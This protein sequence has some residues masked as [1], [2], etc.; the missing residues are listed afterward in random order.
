MISG[1]KGTPTVSELGQILHKCS[2]ICNCDRLFEEFTSNTKGPGLLL[3]NT[4]HPS[5]DSS[6]CLRTLQRQLA[7]AMRCLYVSLV[8]AS[9]LQILSYSISHCFSLLLKTTLDKTSNHTLFTKE[10]E[11]VV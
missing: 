8:T 9:V 10:R 1:I 11:G 3:H 6:W 4:A 7:S 2:D 5:L